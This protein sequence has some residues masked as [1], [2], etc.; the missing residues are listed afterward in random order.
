MGFDLVVEG[1]LEQEEIG[2][3]GVLLLLAVMGDGQ[4][5]Q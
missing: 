4:E 3:G 2:F 1:Y 5:D